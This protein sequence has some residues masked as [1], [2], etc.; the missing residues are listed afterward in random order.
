[1]G[2]WQQERFEDPEETMRTAHERLQGTIWTALPVVVLND[3]NGHTVEVQPTVM[4]V[5][6]DPTTGDQTNVAMPSLGK[7]VP[8]HY[9]SGGGFTFTH[10]IKKGDEGI[11]VIA[12]RC[13][14]GWFSQGG[15][16]PQLEQRMHDLSDGMFIP[17]IR[18]NPRALNPA[19]SANSAQL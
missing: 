5:R 11:V 1:M 13:I 2:I 4:G 3:S 15:V 6:T 7:S 14:D 16:Q 19:A 12:S 9:P 17:G 10:P 8:V 18:S